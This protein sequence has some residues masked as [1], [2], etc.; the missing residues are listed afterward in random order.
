M[1][2]TPSR[3]LDT[4]PVAL[5]TGATG[6]LGLALV[7][8]LVREGWHVF[9]ADCDT[10]GLEALRGENN[11]TPLMIDVTQTASIEAVRAQIQQ[12]VPYLDAVVNFAGVLRVGAMV[13]VEE[14][15]FM[16]LMDINLFGTYRV[17]KVF[18]PML[19]HPQKPGR[20]V[21]ISSETGWHT[22]APFNG[23]Y[24]IS[25]HGIEAYSDALRRELS[26]FGIRVIKVQPG[27]FKTSMVS[28]V[29]SDFDR[30]AEQ[31]T[32]YQ[33]ALHRWG[34]FTNKANAK[35]HPPEYL[36]TVIH[37]ALTTANPKHAYSVRADRVRTFME[38]LPMRWSDALF[39]KMIEKS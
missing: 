21:N 27:P 32:L 14:A 9:A 7:R 24:A 23:P 18:F 17:N 8:H 37:Q 38:Y 29:V 20:I 5:I 39:R 1:N 6:G 13:E 11:I 35:A 33:K 16:R 26:I 15:L 30:A 19:R 28:G 34:V 12:Q 4:T 2:Q 10:K 22:A 25:K 3:P 31:S 36:A